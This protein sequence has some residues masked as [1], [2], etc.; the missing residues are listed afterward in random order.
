MQKCPGLFLFVGRSM[1]SWFS[2]V[3]QWS[4]STLGHRGTFIL[5]L[6]I[7][8]G[9]AASGPYFSYSDTWQLI[10]NTGT[11]VVT[12]LMVFLLQ[13]SQNRDTLAVQAKLDELLRANERARNRLI[14][15]ESMSIEDLQEIKEGLAKFAD[16][17]PDIADEMGTR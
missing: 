17:H 13:A 12:F 7:V 10:I 11:T 6:L 1:N 5:A 9:W 8:L 16:K 3:A 4:A 15:L 14:G 2:R